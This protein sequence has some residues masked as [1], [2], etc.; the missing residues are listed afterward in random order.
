MFVGGELSSIYLEISKKAH[1]TNT[2]CYHSV[3][4]YSLGRSMATEWN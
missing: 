1:S 2:K 4:V 3:L